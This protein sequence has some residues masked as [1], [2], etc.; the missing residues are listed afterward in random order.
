MRAQVARGDGGLG[1]APRPCQTYNVARRTLPDILHTL[2][3]LLY[4]LASDKDIC[5]A[6]Y[7]PA[8]RPQTALAT[9]DLSSL[10]REAAERRYSYVQ[11][12]YLKKLLEF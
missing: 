5:E 10:R 2:S 1:T 3:L 11:R 7:G 4:T 6:E 9:L 8:Q 12:C